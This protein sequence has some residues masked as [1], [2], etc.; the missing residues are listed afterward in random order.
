MAANV[1]GLLCAYCGRDRQFKSHASY[2]CNRFCNK[3]YNQRAEE[4]YR[5]SHYYGKEMVLVEISP[6]W[7]MVMMKEDAEAQGLKVLHPVKALRN[8]V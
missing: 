7:S 6:K 5:Q 3:C 8:G 4:S 2:R 1:K